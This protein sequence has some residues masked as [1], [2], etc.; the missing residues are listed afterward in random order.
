M[1]YSTTDIAELLASFLPVCERIANAVRT[2]K[3]FVITIILAILLFY[4]AHR[5]RASRKPHRPVPQNTERAKY[6][7]RLDWCYLAFVITCLGGYGALVYQGYLPTPSHKIVSDTMAQTLAIIDFVSQDPNVDKIISN[8]DLTVRKVRELEECNGEPICF[9]RVRDELMP[10][11]KYWERLA[12]ESLEN[13][14]EESTRMAFE[15]LQKM[16]RA[17][18]IHKPTDENKISTK[19]LM[20]LVVTVIFNHL[21]DDVRSQLPEYL[22][23]LT[24]EKLVEM[25]ATLGNLTHKL[26][27][28]GKTAR[29]LYNNLEFLA[30]ITGANDFANSWRQEL[31]SW[32]FTPDESLI[33]I[34]T[35]GPH[36]PG[37]ILFV[38]ALVKHY[39]DVAYKVKITQLPNGKSIT[40]GLE[41]TGVTPAQFALKL[42]FGGHGAIYLMHIVKIA[43]MDYC[44]AYFIPLYAIILWALND[45]RHIYERTGEFYSWKNV[46]VTFIRKTLKIQKRLTK[47][48]GCLLLVGNSIGLLSSALLH[49]A[50][51]FWRITLPDW[52]SA[53]LIP[54]P[55]IKKIV[56]V[57]IG[58]MKIHWMT[59][60]S[61]A[62]V[63]VLYST[64]RAK[65]ASRKF[66]YL[67][68]PADIFEKAREG[69]FDDEAARNQW[70]TVEKSYKRWTWINRVLLF[71]SWIQP[72]LGVMIKYVAPML[73]YDWVLQLPQIGSLNLVDGGINYIW[74]YGDIATIP[75][76][77][78]AK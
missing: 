18:Q 19:K 42:F 30:Y 64:I 13:E 40:N 53:V 15:G 75:L 39:V 73:G 66:D 38:R 26:A 61:M 69:V 1:N 17:L 4:F 59:V 12:L 3:G 50:I 23:V 43:L 34:G 74:S 70:N 67:R 20:A 45:L 14:N 41:P 48:L 58:H 11:L 49:W 2:T 22:A 77:F 25:R 78:F 7:R 21:P 32:G 6:K 54:E 24:P 33:L 35:L 8:C 27:Q 63:A 29:A 37:Q 36:V 44:I 51:Q 5:R 16:T 46:L 9:D 52:A 56:T 47:Y 55:E 62:I 71:V 28:A 68:N 76:Q 60:L 72:V 65:K 31:E 10:I 57:C